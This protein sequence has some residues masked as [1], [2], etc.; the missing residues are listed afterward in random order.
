[1]KPFHLLRCRLVVRRQILAREKTIEL[2]SMIE[3]YI[4]A[5]YS[6]A[7]ISKKRNTTGKNRRHSRD[8]ILSDCSLWKAFF[9]KN[10]CLHSMNWNYVT[11]FHFQWSQRTKK[12]KVNEK[13]TAIILCKHWYWTFHNEWDLYTSSDDC[14]KSSCLFWN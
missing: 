7:C 14:H 5:T 1:M 4:V 10:S 8:Y 11:A 9:F 3:T 2:E 6:R 12:R 13:D